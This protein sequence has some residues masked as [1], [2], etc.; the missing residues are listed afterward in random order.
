MKLFRKIKMM[1]IK[2]DVLEYQKNL[3]NTHY[4]EVESMYQDIRKWRHNYR[5]HLQV[6]KGK[7]LYISFT[8]LTAQKKQPK[9]GKM[10]NSSK[11][12]GRGLGLI[13]VDAIVEKYYGYLS[14]NSEDG[15]FT[16]EILI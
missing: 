4:A 16:T 12:S 14:R 1:C 5:N 3:L 15:A 6:M 2:E 11:G 7:K 13:S 8:N 9:F 10:F